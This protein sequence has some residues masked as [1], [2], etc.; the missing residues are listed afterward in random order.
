MNYFGC[1]NM[2]PRPRP[3]FRARKHLHNLPWEELPLYP[4]KSAWSKA[5]KK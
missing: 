1:L 4:L 2:T 5:Q 3:R